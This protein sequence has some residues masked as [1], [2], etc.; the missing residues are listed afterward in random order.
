MKIAYLLFAYKNPRLI[1]R[2]IDRLACDN[3]SFFL[4]IDRKSHI[5]EFA[6]LRGRNVVFIDKRIPVYWAEFSGIDA[7]LLLIRC[8][9][10]AS[11]QCDYLVLLSGS[12]YPLRSNAYI[13]AFFEANRGQEFITLK[14][15]P[16][17]GKPLARI[18][19]IRFPTTQPALRL[20]FRALAKIGLARRDYRNHLGTLEPYSGLTWWA[21]SRQ[22]CEYLVRFAD[23][24]PHLSDYFRYVFAPE[25][26]FVHTILGNSPFQSQ[27]RRNIVFEDWSNCSKDGGHPAMIQ[28]HHVTWMENQ[29]QVSMD[30]LHGP[31]ELLFARKFAD[32]DL[33]LTE[34]IDRM[35]EHKE[36]LHLPSRV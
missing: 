13:H 2:V 8:A 35:I 12:E 29:D 28:D 14:K 15:M 25:E 23:Q 6:D 33:C 18:N 24:N 27:I 30:D 10:A 11:P 9:L 21:L 1:Q 3:S 32:E 17:P 4:H 5:G 20:A 26:S 34:R 22:A 7:I 16:A 19:T 31:G 36:A